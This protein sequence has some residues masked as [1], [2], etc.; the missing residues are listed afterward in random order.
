[1]SLTVFNLAV[2]TV[3]VD[4]ECS[5]MPEVR[6]PDGRLSDW[7]EVV[8]VGESMC[9]LRALDTDLLKRSLRHT[10]RQIRE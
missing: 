7:I 10:A 3:V 5:A 4:V 1:V 9:A 2:D 6:T 8:R